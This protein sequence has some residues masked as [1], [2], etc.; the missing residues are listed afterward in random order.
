M[1]TFVELTRD[2]WNGISLAL[3]VLSDI[4]FFSALHWAY[5]RNQSNS[6]DDR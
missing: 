6:S 2:D 5:S 3:N 4:I 1:F